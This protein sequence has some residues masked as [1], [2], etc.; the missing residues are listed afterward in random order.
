M[1]CW[2]QVMMD[3]EVSDEQDALSRADREYDAATA[4]IYRAMDAN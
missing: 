1:I 4:S 2:T 3:M